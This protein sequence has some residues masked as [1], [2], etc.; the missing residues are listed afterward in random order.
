[1]VNKK[2]VVQNLTVVHAVVRE[3]DGRTSHVP[4]TVERW[5][6]LAFQYNVAMPETNRA[7]IGR[8]EKKGSARK[9]TCK[10]FQLRHSVVRTTEPRQLKVKVGLTNV[11]TTTFVAF[12]EFRVWWYVLFLYFICIPAETSGKCHHENAATGTLWSASVFCELH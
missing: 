7:I 11:I 3:N 8:I 12:R 2:S 9:N 4:V 6:L 10:V 5:R 1:M